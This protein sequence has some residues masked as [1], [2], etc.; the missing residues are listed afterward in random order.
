M[1]CG[2]A[3][4]DRYLG[5][6][7]SEV[8]RVK[9]PGGDCVALEVE[10]IE[11]ERRDAP[12]MV[13]LHEGLGSA[14]AWGDWPRALCAAAGCRGLVYSRCGYGHSQALPQATGGWPVDY[15]EREARIILPSLF[16][17]LGIDP[18]SERPLIFGHSD[19]GTIALM[20]A[21]AFPQQVG[22]LVVAAPHVFAE[23]I[24]RE[25]IGRLQA[26]WG[27]GR[28]AERLARIHDD[29]E[30]VFMGW[31]GCWLAPG[32]RNWDISAGLDSIACPVLA[33]QGAQDQFGTLEQLER[34]KRHVPHAELLV[35]DDCRHVPHEEQ[36]QAVLD[37]A[38][39]FLARRR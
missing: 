22:A 17:A 30:G 27:D 32:F 3:I 6:K 10:S 39:A 23:D 21:A 24:A 1:A 8:V 16:A 26:S 33:V 13:F 25:R 28:L 12:L 35:L 11:S 14:G 7:M 15:M 4:R 18:A 29:P 5:E 38:V 36:P 2:Y 20:Y 19:G 9:L 31:S 34:I 37:A